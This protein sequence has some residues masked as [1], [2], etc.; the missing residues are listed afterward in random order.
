MN[1]SYFLLHLRS[2]VNLDNSAEEELRAR[3]KELS[4]IKGTNLLF[5]GDLCKY[6]YF[7]KSG[8]FRIYTSDGFEDQTIDFA[9]ADS[10]MTAIDGF[11][12][13]QITRE[14]IVCEED[15]IVFRI[16]Y[17]PTSISTH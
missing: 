2:R 6:V 7:I 10:F 15:A 17:H 3:V 1:L 4:V 8:F 11:F 9:C 12:T 5:P 13:Q 14:G 16:S